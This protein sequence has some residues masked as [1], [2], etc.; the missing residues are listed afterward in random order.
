MVESP[1]GIA[2]PVA[3]ARSGLPEHLYSEIAQ[4]ADELSI[5]RMM[6]TSRAIRQAVEQALKLH[7][8]YVT[9]TGDSVFKEGK[10]RLTCS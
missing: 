6:A 10:F 7:L 1:Q 9:L 8:A 2:L 3:T 4:Y 5:W